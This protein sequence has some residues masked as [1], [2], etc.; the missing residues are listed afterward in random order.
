MQVVNGWQDIV[1]EP[2]VHSG[3]CEAI[4]HF[5][6]AIRVEEGMKRHTNEDTTEG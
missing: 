3:Y 6:S 2:C 5:A 1:L 4:C